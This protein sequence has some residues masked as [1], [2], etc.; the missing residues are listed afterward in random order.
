MTGRTVLLFSLMAAVCLCV[1]AQEDCENVT[2]GD[3]VFLVDGSSSISAQNFQEVRTFLR[4]IINGFDI[5]PN[6]VQ[7]GLAQYSDNPH[8]EFMLK[9]YA[10]KKSLLAAVERLPQRK[11]GTFTGKA[12]DFLLRQYFNKEAGSRANKGVPQITVV[13]TDGDSSDDVAQP[14][15]ELRSKGVVLFSIG[16]GKVKEEQLSA[17]ANKPPERFSLNIDNYQALQ[18][19]TGNLL[20][21][22]CYT[23]VQQREALL[24]KFADTFLLVDNSINLRQFTSFRNDLINEINQY[25]IGASG[26]RYGLAQYSEEVQVEF[27]LKTHQTKQQTLS[28]LRRVRLRPKPQQQHNM[29]SALQYAK[30]NFFTAEAGGRAEQGARQV[31]VVVTGKGSDDEVYNYAYDLKDQGIYLVGVAAPGAIDVVRSLDIFDEVFDFALVPQLVKTL[32][33]L[34]K[35][36]VTQ[37]C[38]IANVADIVFIVDESG[39]IGV[40]NFQ[41]IRTFLRSMVSNLDIGQ[42]NVRVGIV[43]YND[44]PRPQAYLNTF[45]SKDEIL[46]YI[47]ILPYKGGGTNTG[48]ALNFTLENLFIPARGSR[49]GVQKVAVVIT[50]GESQD[51]VSEAAIRLRRAGVTIY[52]VGIRA[53]NN[54][55]L[56]QMASHPSSMHVFHVSD[57]TML[58]PLQKKLQKRLCVNIIKKA[59][60]EVDS[61]TDI[62]EAC[63]QND[64]ADIFFLMDDSG[65]ILHEDFRDMQ[66]FIIEFLNTF[67]IGQ[68]HVRMGCVKYSDSP[69]LVF[70]LTTNTNVKALEKAVRNIHHAGGGTNTGQALSFMGPY[71]KNA[72]VTR[73]YK[74]PEYL[75]VITDGE[76]S[77]KVKEPAK[78]LRD[79][80]III[81]AIGVKQANQ[82][83]LNEIAGDPKRTFFVNNFDALNSTNMGLIT[84]ICSSEACKDIP[85]D[86]IFLVD[87]S[88]AI[89]KEN[90]EKMKDFMK[91]VIAK[92]N[93]GET[94]MHF[95]V[96]QF[97]TRPILEFNL[98]SHFRKEE[99]LTAIET[100]KQMNERTFTGRALREVSQYFDAAQGGR[101]NVKQSLV[102]ITGSKAVDELRASAEALR[103]KGV[104]VYSIGLEDAS[105]SQLLEMSGSSE[106]VF[107]EGSFDALKELDN[108]LA[109]KFC[110][111]RRDC[112]KTQKADIIFLVDGSGSISETQFQSMKMFM[113]SIV[114]LTT[115]G[116]DLTR[117][118][119]ILYSNTPQSKFT[120]N[121]HQSKGEV[122]AAINKLVAPGQ[123]TYTGRALNYSLDYFKAEHGGRKQ[124]RV[125]QIIMVITDGEATDPEKL[126]PSSDKLRDNGITVF[127]IGV[128]EAKQEELLVMAGD[129]Q[130]KVFKVEQFEDLEFLYKSISP[131]LCNTT[132]S[133]CS[134]TDLVFLLDY[135]SSINPT[136]HEIMKSFT[137]DV[138]NSFKVGEKFVRVG[139]AQF[140]DQPKHEFYLNRYYQNVDATSHIGALNYTGGN[141]YLGKALEHIKS[142]FEESLGSRQSVPR[143]LLVISDGNSHDEVEDEADYLR[144]MGIERFA[145]AVGDVYD[146]KLL[147]ITGTPEK[148]F[149]VQNFDSLANIK[150]KV[151]KA[152]C[153]DEPKPLSVC[154]IDIAVAFDIS[155]KSGA[156][157]SNVIGRRVQQLEDIISAISSVGDLCCMKGAPP[158]KT[159]IAFHV[160][161]SYDTNFEFYSED[162]VRKVSSYSVTR[163]TYF[164][165]SMLRFFKDRF[166]TKSTASVKVLLIFTDGLDENPVKLKYEAELLRTSGVSALLTVALDNADHA[167]LQMVEFGRGFTY[168]YPLRRPSTIL[169]QISA[170][171]DRECC[172]V[173]C[174][175]SGHEGIR[176][177]PGRKG[178]KGGLGQRGQPGFQGEEGVMGD[179]GPPGSPGLQGIQGCPGQRGQKGFRG[180]SGTL[181]EKGEDGLD[182]IDGEQGDT[183]RAGLAGDR[184][185][186]GNQ[187]IPG[188]RGEEGPKGQRGLR[189]D[190]GEPGRDNTQRGPKGGVGNPGIP[191]TPGQNG[192]PGEGGTA[193]NQ[194]P[195]GRRG[196]SGVKGDPGL[197]GS[198][199]LSG[200]P[201]ASGPQGPRG[202]KGDR[203]PKGLP[204]FSGPQGER[205]LP[206]DPGPVGRRGHNG[207]KGQPGEPGIKGAPGSQGARGAPGLDGRDGYGPQG[208]PGVKGDP[209]FPGYQGPVG[210]DGEPGP[211]GYPGQ[212][213][214]RGRRGNSGESG[215]PGIPGDPGRPGR[216]GPRGPPGGKDMTE[217]QLVSY[218]R[219]NCACSQGESAC[220][221]FPTELVFGLDMSD[222]VTPVAFERQRSAL[223]SLLEDIS[224]AESNCPTGARVAV[225]E[226][227]T[228]TK[229]L[230]R[231]Q[232]YRRKDQLIEA[233]KNIA[234][235]RTSNRRHLGAAMRFVGQHVFKRVRSGVMMR[236]VAVFFSDEPT[237]E[238]NDVVTAV[239]EYRGLNIVPAVISL[240]NSP[241]VRRAMEVDDSGRS[242]FVVLGRQQN[243][244]LRRVKNCAICYDPCRRSEECSFIQDEQRPQEV[245]VDLALVVDSSR[246]VQ[247]DEYA[248]IQQLLGSVVEQL[249]VSPQPR[250]AGSQARVAVVQQSGL[251]TK[252]EFNLQT[253]QNQKQMKTYL[254]QTMRQQGGSSLLGQ[255]LDYTL[256]EV[257]LQASQPRRRKAVLTV[258]STQTAWEDRAKLHYV[259]Q[260][261]KCEGVALFVVALGGRYNRTQVEELASLPVAQHLVHVSRLK[262]EEQGYVQRFFRAFL[263]TLNKNTNIYPPPSIKRTCSQLREIDDDLPSMGSALPED[264]YSE[265][266]DQ[267]RIVV[268]TPLEPLEVNTLRAGD[269]QG[270]RPGAHIRDVC[271]LRKDRGTCDQFSIM[272]FYDSQ[273]GICTRFWY[274]GCGGNKNRFRSQKECEKECLRKS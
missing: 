84:D 90:F 115:V 227:N 226:Y 243:Q 218:I 130:S 245:E 240:R 69:S 262:E 53:T 181:G 120:L 1:S 40:P 143:S 129:D 260:K 105:T 178:T 44:M 229:Y 139:V 52:A 65:S 174:K 198:P 137:A 13:I 192:R 194:G 170:V 36:N 19:L 47:N 134:Q 173:M 272:W 45:R 185:R 131:A 123:N 31:L 199:G 142:Y 132:K 205:G 232:D 238:V 193:G 202:D 125:P 15:Q 204:G 145:I 266:A 33:T 147:Q 236:K 184:G 241:D 73:G 258:V 28:A 264:E 32:T 103:A 2:I 88:K 252:A 233:V 224:I 100:M 6:K 62:T 111:L 273:Q 93:V 207:Q 183:G 101:P 154:S 254:T 35:Q 112:K 114:N 159:K 228:Y 75:I 216:M 55:Q 223:L 11:G 180:I 150:T 110:D 261:A 269:N 126:K 109:L 27:L 253:Y 85:G 169:Q 230:I 212:D 247:A 164:N 118:G 222:G 79:Q 39:S 128:K 96:M 72:M 242:M 71:F 172:G 251:Q 87:S 210:E 208:P 56:K 217:C 167:E 58:E 51:S 249:A 148:L 12:L 187:G 155:R 38:K 18:A 213:G 4:T 46:Q 168:L 119:V 8:Q 23:I 188:I 135:S 63:K 37:D 153:K 26:F 268:R 127:S 144:D 146:L 68:Q 175:C 25:N 197:P 206:G 151:I 81:Y 30:S 124:L 34:P 9:D 220:P 271:L 225:V 200:V 121:E 196:P 186:P 64:E 235:E 248:G 190:P 263:S 274:G 74:V 157:G 66:N 215:K 165:S 60:I 259:S 214:N 156:P 244:D 5:G 219:E 67:R 141:T 122:L 211:K 166:Q 256:K 201:G 117:F 176:G 113:N 76:S 41:L 116:R 136:D 3:I 99:L 270:P 149:T 133:D 89:S 221:A 98:L 95:G 61:K 16:V 106:N 182:G 20:S 162:V 48:A 179:R 177:L 189:G 97:S 265:M 191:G 246:E 70:D 22:V 50:D 234:L 42:T 77:D 267:P 14:A 102:V 140:S 107:N 237:Q 171:A 83:Q 49:A 104:V 94:D 17:I 203:G 54:T 10:D 21:T 59:V 257:L 78:E 160:V 24:D 250:R 195:D 108:Q 86:I 255:T 29:G 92:S 80:G 152:L 161:D 57:F 231:F 158:V 91:L 43:T 209:G 163:R 82:T 239:M 138:V 7:I